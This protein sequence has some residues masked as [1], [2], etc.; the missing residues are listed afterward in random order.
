MV[1]RI[2]VRIMS[3][4]L[5]E[6]MKC[7]AC[8][9]TENLIKHIVSE[10][11]ELRAKYETLMAENEVLKSC[12]EPLADGVSIEKDVDDTYAGIKAV[13]SVWMTAYGVKEGHAYLEAIL[14]SYIRMS[15]VASGAK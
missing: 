7:Y 1:D 6:L 11:N 2:A 5:E 15:L 10:L 14:R 8:S 9:D 3:V 13:Y 12:Q 4:L